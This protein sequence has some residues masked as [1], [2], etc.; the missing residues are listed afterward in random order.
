MVVNNNE[1]KVKD[2][3]Y[4]VSLGWADTKKRDGKKVSKS[5]I[6][7]IRNCFAS[8]KNIPDNL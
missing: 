8:I 4:K 6:S 5:L 2:I 3:R 1:E 7:R